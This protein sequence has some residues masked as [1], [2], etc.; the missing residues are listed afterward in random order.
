[1][2]FG[3]VWVGTGGPFGRHSSSGSLS[4]ALDAVTAWRFP[5]PWAASLDART[6]MR[7]VRQLC[8]HQHRWVTFGP[9]YFKVGCLV[10]CLQLGGMDRGIERSVGHG[11]LPDFTSCPE[12]W[13]KEG[14]LLYIGALFSRWLATC[15]SGALC[16]AG[17]SYTGSGAFSAKL[18]FRVLSSWKA[19]VQLMPIC[20]T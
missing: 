8:L 16:V 2:G 9:H 4:L 10:V 11:C 14:V 12:G 13:V 17:G 6:R 7:S 5:R 18:V 15:I 3:F 19:D 20:R 1:M